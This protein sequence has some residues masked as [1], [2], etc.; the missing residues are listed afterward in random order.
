MARSTN[1]SVGSV[2]SEITD[3]R[4]LKKDYYGR[5][6]NVNFGVGGKKAIEGEA[7]LRDFLENKNLSA[8]AGKDFQRLRFANQSLIN[9]NF[10]ETN[11][12]K[13]QLTSTIFDDSNAEKA[14]FKNADLRGVKILKSNFNGSDLSGSDIQQMRIQ[15]SNLRNAVFKNAVGDRLKVRNADFSNA[16]LEGLKIPDSGFGYES[17]FDNTSFE[18]SNFTKVNTSGN[19]FINCSF[20]NADLTGSNFRGTWWGG[21]SDFTGAK[22]AGV[23][24]AGATG[25]SEKNKR[26]LLNNGAAL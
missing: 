17:H 26:Y 3:S 13:G 11:F 1:Q 10:K 18:N 25:L 14:R 20:K 6:P 5:L 22:V 4:Y 23:S 16:N 19:F 2:R 8:L 12:S 15:D 21:D 9:G 7:V 24:F